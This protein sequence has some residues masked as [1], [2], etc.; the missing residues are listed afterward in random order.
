MAYLLKAAILGTVPKS[1]VVVDW[2]GLLDDSP[3]ASLAADATFWKSCTA[4]LLTADVVPSLEYTI[5]V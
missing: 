3:A 2:S 5:A 1:G 4:M